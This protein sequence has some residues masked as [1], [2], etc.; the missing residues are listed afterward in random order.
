MICPKCGFELADGKLYCESCGEEIHMVPDFEPEIETSIAQS[1]HAVV[2][3]ING[4]D[5]EPLKE[6]A[7]EDAPVDIR[8]HKTKIAFVS[9]VTVVIISIVALIIGATIYYHFYSFDYLYNKFCKCIS[10]DNIEKA[11]TYYDK[12][13]KIERNNCDIRFILAD[14]YTKSD[15]NEAALSIWNDIITHEYGT[16]DELSKAYQRVI[17][18]YEQT[19]DYDRINAMLLLC[20]NPDVQNQF[21]QY[22]AKAPEY[23][24]VE[25]NYD[26]VIPLK[27]TSN[28]TGT[29]YYTLD[30][31]VPSLD[32]P[33]YMTPIF[34]ETGEYIVSSFFVN[35]YGV[36][37]ETV[38]KRFFIDIPIP[39]A[40]E[41][42]VYSGEY[43]VP[44]LIE[45]EINQGISVYYTTDGS[46]PNSDST[47][48]IG[49]IPM[50][51]GKSQFKFISYNEEGI[52]G[53]VTSRN[54]ELSL[55]ADISVED[56]TSLVIQKMIEIGKIS[57]A[58]GST[59]DGLGRYLYKFQHVI[60]IGDYGNYYFIAEIFEDTSG[61]SNKS[62]VMY[63]V[64]INTGEV[65]RVSG[66]ENGEYILTEI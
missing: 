6:D 64:N 39:N 13:I 38:S 55:N 62:G 36:Q 59:W 31:S 48:Y 11:I 7:F 41:V 50:P 14:Y 32:S 10:N 66:D 23:S 51:I 29:I 45:V 5:E 60:Q 56:A 25:G 49:A 33:I 16:V 35:E 2:K 26:E 1:I 37:S 20:T 30:G 47:P 42:S 3:E 19:G 61:L 40:P 8:K 9:S 12:A 24:Y 44:T 22:L 28:T 63:A 53:E 17:A 43:T 21:Q 46:I 27:L 58:Q 52:C 54:Y 65:S 34:L 4:V 15:N 18:Y 57:D